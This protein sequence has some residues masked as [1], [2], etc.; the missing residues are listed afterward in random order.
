MNDQAQDEKVV[1]DSV[2][3]LRRLIGPCDGKPD[4]HGWQKCR[5]CAAMHLL[6]NRDR[7]SVRL[8]T[9]AIQRLAPSTPPRHE[10]T[11]RAGTKDVYDCPRC[12]MW[13]ANLPLYKNDECEPRAAKE[14]Q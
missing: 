6:E 8:F 3:L 14:P 1:A 10:W 12:G 11:L 2:K 9:A 7:T 4:G 13:T 5:R